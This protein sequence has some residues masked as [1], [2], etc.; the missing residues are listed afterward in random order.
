M[1]AAVVTIALGRVPVIE[2]KWT[3]RQIKPESDA[4]IRGDMIEAKGPR[5]AVDK[6]GVVK[7]CAARFFDNRKSPFHSRASQCFA[8]GR[9]AVL[10]LRANF[11]ERKSPKI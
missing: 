9:F 1:P 4:D 11:A 8:A 7:D 3:D 6:T 10:I 2:A 5:L